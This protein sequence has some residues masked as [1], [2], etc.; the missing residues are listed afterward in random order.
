M[1]RGFRG[2]EVESRTSFLLENYCCQRSSSPS[3][4]A[5]WFKEMK[6]EK[7]QHYFPGILLGVLSDEGMLVFFLPCQ[8][9]RDT[10]N[11]IPTVVHE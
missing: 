1:T 4:L 9:A 5:T 7:R 10:A 8:T 11:L 2:L 6:V 3:L